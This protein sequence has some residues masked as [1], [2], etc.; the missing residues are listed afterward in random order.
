MGDLKAAAQRE[1]KK[2]FLRRSDRE[3]VRFVWSRFDF[4]MSTLGKCLNCLCPTWFG[5]KVLKKK[6]LD[7]M[8]RIQ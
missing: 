6:V 3:D 2:N 8:C 5:I 7:Y 1:L 4:W